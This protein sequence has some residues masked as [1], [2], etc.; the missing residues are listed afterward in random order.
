MPNSCRVL[1]RVLGDTPLP[2][3][4]VLDV[5]SGSGEDARWL[6]R[7]TGR[8]GIALDNDASLRPTVVARA[9]ALP[10]GD[11]CCSL[12]LCSFLLHLLESPSDALAEMARVVNHGG[13][14]NVVTL[15]HRQIRSRFLNAYF[16]SL[17]EIDLHRY[18]SEQTIERH[19]H[20]A[21]LGSVRVVSVTVEGVHPRPDFRDVLLEGRWS[22]L[23]FLPAVEREEGIERVL[24]DTAQDAGARRWSEERTIVAGAK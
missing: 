2:P 7:R 22:S 14:V 23:A 20:A 8:L 18:P 19:M 6:A 10:L 17:S 15:S 11:T 12:V 9:E 21:G 5:G 1:E 16:P 13:R 24:R 4:V 3:G